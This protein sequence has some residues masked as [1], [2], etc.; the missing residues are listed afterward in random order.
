MPHEKQYASYKSLAPK[1][2]NKPEY[3]CM[4]IQDLH[5]RKKMLSENDLVCI[6]IS[7]TWCEPCKVIGPQFA[8]LSQQ[9]NISGKCLLAKENVDLELTR[10]YQITGIPAFIFYHNGRLVKE[11]NG[12][13]VH[14]VGGDIGKVQQI[15]DKFLPQLK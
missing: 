12:N 2:N 6:Y 10:D 14:V 9:Y 13:P 5:H 1:E 3:T 4:E 7:G 8:K 15:L 11:K